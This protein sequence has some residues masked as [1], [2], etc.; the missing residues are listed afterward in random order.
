MNLEQIS[1]KNLS[2]DL[3]YLFGVYLTDGSISKYESYSFSLKA[4]DKD[5]V[6]H[7]LDSFKRI[8]PE[9][10]AKIFMQKNRTRYWDDGRISKTQDQYCIG[11][12]FAKFGDFFKNQTNSKHH[13]PYLIWDAPLTI[14]KWFIAGVMDGN[15]WISKTKRKGWKDKGW[16]GK[17]NGYQ[18]RIGIGKTEES[19]IHE[20]KDLLDKMGVKTLKKEIYKRSSR[21]KIIV[22]FGIKIDSFVSNGLFFTIKRKQDRVKLL[23][24]VQR[25]DAAD[26]TG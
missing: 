24:S 11:L 9:S 23:R 22:R 18:Y 12:G 20:F 15:G 6:Q 2:K 5:F 8:H 21:N 19:W 26:P 25:L 14:K 4:I 7:T 1:S 13:I 3:A 17:Y 16:V 10:K